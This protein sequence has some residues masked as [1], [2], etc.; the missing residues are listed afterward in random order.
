MKD[1]PK[2]ITSRRSIPMCDR[3]YK[4]LLSEEHVSNDRVVKVYPNIIERRVNKVCAANNLP[5]IGAHGLRHSFASLAYYLK[6]P[7]KVAME[8]GG[9]ANDTTMKKI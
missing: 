7:E 8:I 2:N 3:L 1:T 6:I 5:L 9:W 4:L